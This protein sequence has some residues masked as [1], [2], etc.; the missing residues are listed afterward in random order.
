MS[1]LDDLIMWVQGKEPFEMKVSLPRWVFVLLVSFEI[2][3]LIITILALSLLKG[4]V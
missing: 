2:F 4:K 1:K 3:N